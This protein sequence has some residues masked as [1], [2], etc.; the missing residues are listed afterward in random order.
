MKPK[1]AS[2]QDSQNRL[3]SLNFAEIVNGAALSESKIFGQQHLSLGWQF[4]CASLPPV[5]ATL[6]MQDFHDFWGF[7]D[8][9]QHRQAQNHE[10]A[11]GCSPRGGASEGP[12]VNSFARGNLRGRHPAGERIRR[13][14][15]RRHF[16]ECYSGDA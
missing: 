2:R 6:E 16:G 9:A 5:K 1:S 10:M 15:H 13:I 14:A 7:S 11:E 8:S 12:L 3:R 4:R